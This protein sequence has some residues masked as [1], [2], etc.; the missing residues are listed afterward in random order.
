MQLG[1]V[2]RVEVPQPQVAAPVGDE[3]HLS[4]EPEPTGATSE[5]GVQ[6]TRGDPCIVA[7]STPALEVL[8]MSTLQAEEDDI[9]PVTGLVPSSRLI[10]R[11]SPG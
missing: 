8:M 7:P 6:S 1:F 3:A 9:V 11:S 4:P 5:E 2:E 10:T